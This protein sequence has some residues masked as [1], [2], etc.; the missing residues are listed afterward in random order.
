MKKSYICLT[1]LIVV[2]VQSFGYSQWN[3]TFYRDVDGD[4]WGGTQTITGSYPPPGYVSRG[5]DCND[6]QYTG[7]TTYPGAPELCDGVDNDCDGQ[8]D[9]DSI[10][11]PGAPSITNNCGSTI[12]T[13]PSH[14]GALTLYWQ[15][16]PS[17]T[18]TSNSSN[19]ITRT[20]GTVYYI[21]A[22]ANSG[23]CWGPARTVNYTINSAPGTPST[24]SVTNNCGSSVLTRS[25]PPS[26]IT[27]YWQS[28][29]SGTST[30]NSNSSVTRTSGST[31]YL[32]GRSS[33][34]CWGASRTVT[35]SITQPT[36]WYADTDGDGYGNS[37]STTSDC[38]QP[39]GYVANSSDHDDTTVLVTN[40]TPQTYYSDVDGDGF[41]DGN[42]TLYASFK[43]LGYADNNTDQCP[44]EPGSG[45]GCE[46]I[47][48]T[49]SDEN[50]VS[51]R[52]YQDA[53]ETEAIES[54][55]YFDGLGRTKQNVFVRGS[56]KTSAQTP[57]IAPGW[58]MD[59]SEGTGGTAF[60]N[61]NGE[62]SENARVWAPDPFGNNN[63]VWECGNKPDSGSD[64]GW[65][66]DYF[67]VDKTKTYRY[68]VWV[69]RH[70]SNNGHSYHGTQN[71]DNLGGGANGNPYFWVGDPPQL[72]EWYL[73]VGII[74]P[75]THGSTDTGVSGVYD[76]QGNKVLDGTEFKWRSDTTNSRFRSYLY[77]C[78]D[79]NVR[80][81]F[82][83]PKVEVVDGSELPLQKLFDDG[84]PKDIVTHVEYD[85]YGRASKQYLP[86]MEYNGLGTYRSSSK[87]ATNDHYINTY[88]GDINSGTPNPYSETQFEASPLNRV[89]KQAAPG[90]DWRMGGGHEIEFGY[91][92][93]D[94]NEVRHFS[95]SFSGGNTEAPQL[96]N[97]GTY[98][99]N[100]LYKKVTYDENH[101]SGT[102]HSTEEFTDK[103]GQV[104][105]KRTYN[106]GAHDTYYVYDDFG[107]LTYVLPPKVTVDNVSSTELSELCYQ[108][109]YD[110][111]NRL[112]EKKLPGKGWEE[113]VYDKL[114]RPIMT[115]D[116]NLKALN[117]WLF[118]K[119]DAF[120]RVIYTGRDDNTSSTRAALQN[121]ADNTTDTFEEKRGTALNLAGTNVY[122]SNDAYPTSYN[123]VFTINYYDNYEDEDGL[124]VPTT[125]LGQAATTNTHGLPTVS[126]VRVLGTTNWITTITGYDVKG[127]PI[128]TASKNN[129]LNTTDIVETKLDFAGKVLQ[130]K[131]THTKGA[132]APIVT[133]DDFTYDQAARLVKLEQ[134]IG[135][136]TEELVRNE[137]DELGQLKK[138][139]VGGSLQAVD[140][141][142]NVR[143]WLKQIN[144]PANLGNDLFAFDINYNTADHGG[145]ALYNGNIAETEWKTANDNALRWY[146]YG[147]DALN[148]IENAMGS[149]TNYSLTNVDYDKMGNI[150]TL[151]R[152][153]HTNSAA[154]TFGT[155]DNLVYTYDSG[156]K[157]TKVLD[158]GNDTYGFKDGTDQ[159][160][161]YT[162][163]A[164][165]NMTS[166]LNKGIAVNGIEYNHL[167]MPTKI[168]VSSGNNTGTIDYI[169][170]SDRK[171]LRKISSNGTT[172]DYAGSFV[173]EN[174][175]LKQITQLEGYIEP[176]GNGWQYVYRYVDI[177][178]N[179]R[180][181]Y[182]DDN[183]DGNIIASFEIRREQN[184]YPLG[185]EHKGYNNISYGAEN[186]LNTY[187]G[188]EFTEDLELNIHEWKFRIS[189]PAIGRFWQIDP[190]ADDYVYNSTF[191]FQENKLG[192]GV[193]L[194]G[195]ELF[196]RFKAGMDRMKQG[197]G[198]LL[199]NETGKELNR[200]IESGKTLNAARKEEIQQER[201][202]DRSEAMGEVAE[203]TAEATKGGA[204]IAGTVMEEGGDGLAILSAAVGFGPG[205][206]LGEGISKTGTGINITVDFFDGKS[207]GN[208][209]KERLPGI[210][211][212]QASKKALRATEK[213]KVDT[214]AF[215]AA[216]KIM[217]KGGN[218]VIQDIMRKENKGVVPLNIPE[219]RPVIGVPIEEEQ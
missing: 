74:H 140:Y 73:L 163:D 124:A 11:I 79:V 95:I 176:D 192:M 57:N 44:N 28:S 138:K 202:A 30:S 32:R 162:Y 92:T 116:A 70:H 89:L 125:V 156:N 113:I 81:Y 22:R 56:G 13:K 119:Y 200:R 190:L 215:K 87:T 194:E 78:T 179:T 188:Q 136:H 175:N 103:L 117:Q 68:T 97:H 152:N 51:T 120:G 18:S 198:D 2:L 121:A 209:A 211:L 69:R 107:N 169:Y 196:D 208:I 212:G 49:P 128:Y 105:L 52:I 34:G 5:G 112:V 123:E 94:A 98:P 159:A 129:Y 160:T 100:A 40:L 21:K 16:S 104:L 63:L 20:S 144:D 85:D 151:V 60:F 134:T 53:S 201:L 10:S 3:Q 205:V 168:T 126:K 48:I 108:Y 149:N 216:L 174:G 58:T 130:S 182:A 145:T 203:G 204:Q 132:N 67:N 64:G 84:K 206:A 37:S 50:Y 15:S 31:Y 178:G 106:N 122:Y 210:I 93:N 111:R 141:K 35:Y 38:S 33:S 23:G 161:E 17:G 91:D 131:T 154:T 101:T 76:L 72:E 1:I 43:R 59:W 26:G 8:V 191:A 177:W 219:A 153:G 109:K 133:I 41:G 127:R 4:T 184:Y 7:D 165:G 158:N 66:T 65:N 197:A 155:M 75:Y 102:D 114:N 185:L 39:S 189:D 218:E 55:A 183:N 187:Q 9:E 62:V 172:T 150:T 36:T 77:Y 12:L 166:D 14:S 167:N 96:V 195:A 213:A 181:T 47:F 71:V 45:N 170:S 115:R 118:T 180:L 186:N 143:G 146:R 142:Y 24:P 27:W 207:L 42:T 6:N 173:Y 54:V 135:G 82:Y 90:Y 147:Y 80:Q 137:Y 86:Y 164:N 83:D 46:A 88:P 157:L 99:A 217:E 25:N 148:R 171:K 110:H 199:N 193:E 139:T 29:S 214:D 61:R 19:S